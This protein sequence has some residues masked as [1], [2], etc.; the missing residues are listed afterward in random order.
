MTIEDPQ[1]PEALD[2]VRALCWDYLDVLRGLGGIDAEI[3]TQA[4]PPEKYAAIMENLALEHAPPAGGI[5]LARLNGRPVGCGMFHTLAP[6]TAEIKRVYVAPAARGTGAGRA[7]MEELIAT[8]RASGFERILM[9]TGR[10]LVAA[11]RL[12]DALGFRRR[13]PYQ[14]MPG[15][16]RDNLIYFEMELADDR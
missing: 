14:E 13:G 15:W 8:C 4:Y 3:V 10:P 2:A 7:L 12:Y 5:R 9:D 16:V 6:G 1:G 11:Q